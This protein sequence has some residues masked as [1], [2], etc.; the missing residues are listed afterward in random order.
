MKYWILILTCLS[1]TST[2]ANVRLAIGIGNGEIEPDL[3]LPDSSSFNNEGTT[4]AYA[5]YLGY[6]TD[7]NITLDL[8]FSSMTD[9]LLL[10]PI[11]NLHFD[12]TEALIG[13]QLRYKMGFFEP[14]IGF[15][16]WELTADEGQ[17][18]SPG[19][20]AR[21][22]AD[23]NDLLYMLTGGVNLGKTFALSLSYKYQDYDFGSADSLL[24]G[25]HLNF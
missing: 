23:G 18:F 15:A 9:D 8:G 5:L 17:L 10:G 6:L 14:K 12:T 3:T 22:E 20:E 25:F 2:Y 1:C 13:Y 7:Q 21:I 16:R 19:E 4:V 24:V 11:D